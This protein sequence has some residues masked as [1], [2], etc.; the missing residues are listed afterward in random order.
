MQSVAC[1]EEKILNKHSEGRSIA[2]HKHVAGGHKL[3]QSKGIVEK[4]MQN[5]FQ[6]KKIRILSYL[7]SGI[8]RWPPV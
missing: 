2:S 4:A 8:M 5:D 3:T 1:L 6:K 7:I